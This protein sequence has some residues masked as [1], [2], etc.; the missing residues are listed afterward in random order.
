M[1]IN[2]SIDIDT[3]L[4]DDYIFTMSLTHIHNDFQVDIMHLKYKQITEYAHKRH[5]ISGFILCCS[6]NPTKEDVCVRKP[7]PHL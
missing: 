7:Y 4:V 5:F 3:L 2:K 1:I 6:L